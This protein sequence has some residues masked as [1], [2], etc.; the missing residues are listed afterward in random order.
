MLIVE[1]SPQKL[2]LKYVTV[3]GTEYKKLLNGVDIVTIRFRRN[4]DSVE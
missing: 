3:V 1:D 2:K 4:P